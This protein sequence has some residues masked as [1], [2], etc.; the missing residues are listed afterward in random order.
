VNPSPARLREIVGVQLGI[1][2]MIRFFVQV[3]M[4][5]SSPMLA[6]VAGGLRLAI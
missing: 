5:A 6:S 4:T 2:D 1:L 3:N